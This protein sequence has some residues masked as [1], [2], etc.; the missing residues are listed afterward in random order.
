MKTEKSDSGLH[1][2]SAVKKGTTNRRVSECELAGASGDA[3]FFTSQLLV[4]VGADLLFSEDVCI[5]NLQV[6]QVQPG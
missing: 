3:G 2:Y 4:E 6:A 1:L 5:G